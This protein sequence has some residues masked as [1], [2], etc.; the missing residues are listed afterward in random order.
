MKFQ[1]NCILLFYIFSILLSFSA[2]SENDYFNYKRPLEVPEPMFI[3]LVRPLNAK[4]GDIEINTLF[5]DYTKS[6]RELNWAPEIEFAI[7]DGNS[8][9]F[10]F[11]SQGDRHENYKVAYQ[12][13]L[14]ESDDSPYLNGLQIILESD[15]RFNHFESVL[16]H[17]FAIRF[18]HYFSLLNMTGFKFNPEDI[19]HKALQL[20][21][22]LFYNFS[23]EVDFGLEMNIESAEMG[24]KLN[25]VIPQIHLALG[26]GYQ[27]QYGFGYSK[28]NEEEGHITSFRIVKAFSL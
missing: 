28:R 2:H 22:T 3:D 16:Y 4:K 9:E 1:T 23:E 5:T 10:E 25:Q 11:P 20:N 24:E 8:I 15:K 19:N 7:A 21:T 13:N 27:I 12:R 6:S 18:S 26:E 14:S 17:I